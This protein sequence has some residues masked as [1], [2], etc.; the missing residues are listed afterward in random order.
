MTACR[1]AGR[2]CG[3]IQNK[4]AVISADN[5]LKLHIDVAADP[6]MALSGEDKWNIEGGLSAAGRPGW[7]Y[8]SLENGVWGATEQ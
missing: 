5:R 7:L 4:Y 1:K 3:D 6:L 2:E 8:S